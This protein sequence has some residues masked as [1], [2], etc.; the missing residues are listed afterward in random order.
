MMVYANVSFPA[1]RTSTDWGGSGGALG[2]HVLLSAAQYNPVE[3][4][5][6][7]VPQVHDVPTLI[8]VPSTFPQAAADTAGT[9]THIMKKAAVKMFTG[10][11]GKSFSAIPCK[12]FS[13]S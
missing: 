9:I 3:V 2:K 10:I 11:P 6:V 13:A 12:F 5:Q 1:T 8:C 7:V 4:V